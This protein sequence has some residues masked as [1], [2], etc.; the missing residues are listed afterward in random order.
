MSNKHFL[1]QDPNKLVPNCLKAL[2]YEYPFLSILE[3]ERVVFNNQF[4]SSKVS[5]ISG[6]GSGHEPGFYGLVG[7]GMISAVA[8]GEVFASPNYRNVKAAEK[9]THELKGSS[10]SWGGCIFILTNYT[11]DNLYFG[12]AAQDLIAKYGSDKIK[13]LRVTDDVAVPRTSGALVGRRTLA[14]ITIVSKLTG[15]ASELN[16]GINEIF[17]FGQS[18]I[19]S[20]ASINAGLDHVHISGHK[21]NEDFGKLKPNEL[22]I[23]LG[24]HNEPGVLKLDHIPS[25]EDLVDKLLKMILDKDDKER[26]FFNYSPNDKIVLLINNLG[27]VPIIEEKNILFTSL[28]I[29]KQ[30]YNIIPSR[31]YT[32]NFITSFNAQIFTISLFN[33]TTAVTKTFD[34]EQIFKFLDLKTEAVC[35]SNVNYNHGID[36]ISNDSQIITNFEH[37]D[38]YDNKKTSIESAKNFQIDP[39]KLQNIAS[40]AAQ[41]VVDKEPD[42][43]KWD[44][45]MGDGDCGFGLKLGAELFLEKL[46]KDGIAKDGSLLKVLNVL[47]TIIKDDMGGTLGAILF[48][49][50]KAVINNVEL[51]IENNSNIT[52]IE[53]FSKSFKVGL[54][55]LYDYTKARVGHRTVMD[56]LIPFVESFAKDQDILKS[57]EI[58]HDAAENTKNLKPKLGRATYVGNV[59]GDSI[60][61][62][63]PGAYGIYEAISA[64]SLSVK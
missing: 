60:L 21:S 52:P 8:H 55:T 53:A 7:P 25:N 54:E 51:L 37:Y 31:V 6:G 27:G 24:I 1:P 49:F 18:V 17:E 33:V 48:I 28:Q 64:L 15:A 57:V 3:K 41:R 4:D 59:D 56:V 47:L 42:L 44:T 61:P 32:G 34:L 46:N 63:D 10:T 38:E 35:W 19:D 2:T 62:P 30:K 58:A 23:G 39:I 40:I 11:G 5:L 43:T 45:L 12:M 26:G 22:E 36:S 13:I 9:I 50:L 14:G 16:Y 29:L 20:I